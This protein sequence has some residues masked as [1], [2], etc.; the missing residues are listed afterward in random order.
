MNT[1]ELVVPPLRRWL[2]GKRAALLSLAIAGIAFIALTAGGIGD[3][4]VYY[5]TPTDLQKAG[6]SA[7]GASIR[8]GGMVKDGSIVRHGTSSVE[9]D[10]TDSTGSVRVVTHGVPPQMFRENIGVVV[11]GTMNRSGYFEG[12][13]LLVSHGNEY[14]A[15]DK[16]HA[17]NAEELI[18]S[19]EG[20][21]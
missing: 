5:W 6:N 11:E 19:T 2:N 18:K 21:Q 9:F 4:L 17:V 8:L 1:S 13:R 16:D 20:L 3:N 15:P 7:Y 10:V 14:K 12:N